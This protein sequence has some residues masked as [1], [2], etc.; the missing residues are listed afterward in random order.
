MR[1]QRPL[2]PCTCAVSPVV[3]L[4]GLF[5]GGVE[6]CPARTAEATSKR[7]AGKGKRTALVIL[8]AVKNPFSP[9]RV[10]RDGT[11]ST[12]PSTPLRSAQDDCEEKREHIPPGQNPQNAAQRSGCVLE[13]RSHGAQ[14]KKRRL[15][16]APGVSEPCGVCFDDAGASRAAGCPPPAA[17]HRAE[18]RTHFSSRKEEKK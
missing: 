12:D 10:N 14:S 9:L 16:Q 1:S 8:N 5:P 15:P 11:G 4:C 2:R 18:A 7:V 13:R 3:A 17:A 6:T